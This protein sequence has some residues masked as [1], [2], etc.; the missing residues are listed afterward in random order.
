MS[1]KST[2]IKLPRNVLVGA[3]VLDESGEAVHELGMGD[4]ATLVTSPTP[5]ELAGDRVRAQFDE[6][7]TVVIESAGY[8]AIDRVTAAAEASNAACPSVASI[9][10][11]RQT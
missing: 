2:W 3:G 5:N 1:A 6:M 11:F 9:L 10:R 7:E 4:R 8:D